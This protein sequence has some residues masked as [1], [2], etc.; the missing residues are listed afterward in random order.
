MKKTYFC[1][2]LLTFQ[3][4]SSQAIATIWQKNVH[5]EAQDLL[6]G[7]RATIDRQILLT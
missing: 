1:A 7:N 5:S 4:F 6:S 3:Q 2:F